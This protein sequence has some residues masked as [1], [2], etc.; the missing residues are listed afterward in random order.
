MADLA[1]DDIHIAMIVADASGAICA[2]NSGAEALFGHPA[3]VALA[4]RVDLVVP[5]DYRDM[6]WAGFNRTMG[7]TWPGH[8]AW[9]DIDGLHRDGSL[10]AL[11][12][13][14][15]PLRGADGLAHGAFAMFR[16]RPAAA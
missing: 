14:L 5:H 10:I 12:V 1:A 4:H 3:Q 13:L 8:E 11:Q 9:G 15:T 7:T 16:R 2:W 6:H